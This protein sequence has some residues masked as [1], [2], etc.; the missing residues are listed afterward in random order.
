M[1]IAIPNYQILNFETESLVISD[2]GISKV[3]SRPIL[4]ALRQIQMSRALTKDELD[5]ILADNGLN[6]AS[7]FEFLEKII[8][9]T[10]AKELYFEK[11]IVVHSWE[12]TAA[13]ED[14]FRQ[15]LSGVVE[16]K[17]FSSDIV[18]SLAGFRCFIVLLCHSYD[19]EG[20]KKIHFDLAKISP[21]S[22]ISVCWPMGGFFCIGQ[23]YISEVGNPCHFCTV[24]RLIHNESVKRVKNNWASAL[25]FC[26]N[27]H[28][29]VPFKKLS[30][31]QELVV[32]GA[33]ISNVKFFTESGV[34]RKYHDDVLC[35]SY[36]QLSDGRIFQ[37]SSSHWYICDC[38]EVRK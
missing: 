28:V 8:P 13:I 35:S 17:D 36:V 26:K 29:N 23:P 20:L 19:Y 32:I 24:D 2:A 37:E 4:K 16:F 11:T 3:H 33:I 5:E 15:E 25:A 9:F 27:E 31:Y 7:A 12:G 30:L 34:L 21:A 6:A 18:S 10:A 22:A 14:L 38:L 1:N